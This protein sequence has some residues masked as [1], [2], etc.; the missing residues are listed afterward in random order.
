MMYESTACACVQI[1]LGTAY[2]SWHGFGF[3]LSS[4]YEQRQ[5]RH[6]LFRSCTVEDFLFFN[7][8]ATQDHLYAN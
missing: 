3:Y 4:R 6:I 2:F 1:Q 5:E 7:G 8:V